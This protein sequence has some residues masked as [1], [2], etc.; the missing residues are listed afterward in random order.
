MVKRGF[1]A[2]CERWAAQYRNE[3]GIGL[4]EPLCPRALA[5]H[6]RVII[7]TPEEIPNLPKETLDHLTSTDNGS[8]SA[9]TLCHGNINLIILNS[10]HSPA[11]QNSNL[12]HELAHLICGHKPSRLDIVNDGVMLLQSYDKIQEEEADLLAATLLLP[13]LGLEEA[14]RQ[15]LNPSAIAKKFRVSQEMATWRINMTGINRQFKAKI[16]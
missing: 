14:K 11:R 1:K 6:L 15:G 7:W 12:M 4:T 13:R 2:G 16:R 10:S 5:K 3:L 9:A 8:W